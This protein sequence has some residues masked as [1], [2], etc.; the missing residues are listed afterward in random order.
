MKNYSQ[1]RHLGY[2]RHDHVMTAGTAIVMWFGELSPSAASAT[3]CRVLIF[4]SIIAVIPA[5]FANS[6]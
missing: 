1:S 2:V 5:Q 3:V 6:E 4:T